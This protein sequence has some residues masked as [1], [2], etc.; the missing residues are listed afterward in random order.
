MRLIDA[1]KTKEHIEFQVNL[2][3]AMGL[4]EIA[5]VIQDGFVQEIDLQPTIDAVPVV[6]CKDCKWRKT[7]YCKMDV[8]HKDVTIFNARES[9]FCSRGERKG[10]DA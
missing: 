2:L 3:C 10:G 7:P 9:D 4:E 5:K 6:R 8:W 1:E